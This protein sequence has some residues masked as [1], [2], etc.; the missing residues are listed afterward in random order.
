MNLTVLGAG[1]WGTA[2]AV[3]ACAAHPT[4]L[5]ARDGAQAA[6]MQATRRNARYLDD[7]GLP[8]ELQITADF[9]RAIGHAAEGLVLIATPMAALDEML[10]R[11]PADAP[12]VLW[13]CKGFEHGSGSLGHEIAQRV[14]PQG[15]VGVLSGPSFALEVARGQPTA[16]VAASVDARLT[17]QAVD[18]LHAGRLRSTHRP[19]RSASRSAAPSRTCSRSRPASPTA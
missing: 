16:L 12:G 1:A 7:V 2:L 11:L 4:M 13:L 17:R 5:W 19:T 10:R 18:A 8:A 9:G 6:Q 14:V 15:R 3:H